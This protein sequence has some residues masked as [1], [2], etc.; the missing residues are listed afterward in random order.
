MKIQQNSLI[1]LKL[2]V[3]MILFSCEKQLYKRLCPSVRGSV[4]H[5]FLENR[6]F[7]KIQVNSTKF[8]TFRNCWLGHGL[9]SKRF[10]LEGLEWTG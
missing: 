3:K 2:S 6:E 7:K 9:V 1:E 8:T 10:G 5:A 4:G